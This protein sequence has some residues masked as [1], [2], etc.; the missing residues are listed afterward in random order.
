MTGDEFKIADI[1]QD[2]TYSSRISEHETTTTGPRIDLSLL[3]CLKFRG[4]SSARRGGSGYLDPNANPSTNS[5]TSSRGK[6][7]RKPGGRRGGRTS[8]PRQ[9]ADQ[10]RR[11]HRFN[12]TG[13]LAA[14][15]SVHFIGKLHARIERR[16]GTS[17]GRAFSEICRPGT[18]FRHDFSP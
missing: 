10:T 1:S 9:A 8:H 4:R 11:A 18:V 6:P 12:G 7:G 3:F 2:C 17:H 16:T 13:R 14:D 5:R 15:P